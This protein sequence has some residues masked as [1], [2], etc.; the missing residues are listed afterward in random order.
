MV[1]GTSET[2]CCRWARS[3]PASGRLWAPGGRHGTPFTGSD[4]NS[5]GVSEARTSLLL[6]YMHNYAK[7]S[8]CHRLSR[9]SRWV[10]LLPSR[11]PSS[12]RDSWSCRGA[13]FC[14][15]RSSLEWA[16][17][18]AHSSGGGAVLKVFARSARTRRLAL[19][20]GWKA[21]DR[22]FCPGRGVSRNRSRPHWTKH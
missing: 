8:T 19:D 18:G 14:R 12:R 16:G 5:T 15:S 4:Q 1:G 7:K 10:S 6:H 2:K 21:P 13:V 22:V 11:S 9:Y 20:C 17:V 3:P